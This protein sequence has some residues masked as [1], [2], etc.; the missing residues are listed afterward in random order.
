V[1]DLNHEIFISVAIA[2]ALGALVAVVWSRRG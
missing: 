2:I 1:F